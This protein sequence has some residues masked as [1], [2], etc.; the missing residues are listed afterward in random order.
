MN[1]FH[2]EISMENPRLDIRHLQ[3]IRAIGKTGRVVDAA[4]ELGLTPSALS[5]RIREAER[6]LG[7][8]LFERMHKRLRMT[9][10]AEYLARFSDKF[11][12]EM[13]VIEDEVRRMNA[14]IDHVVRIAVENYS[15]YH[16]FPAFLQMFRAKHPAIDIQIMAGYRRDMVTSLLDRQIDLAI[17]AGES[18][19]AATR[20]LHLF[21]DPLVFV[22]AP[23]HPL[24]G[25]ASVSARD[26][27][28]Q[29]FITFTKIP[30]PDQEF[31]RLFRA[32][33][34]YPNWT[35][36]VELPE[37]IV[38]LVAANQGTSILAQWAV[39]PHVASKRILAIPLGPDPVL[40]NWSCKFRTDE[41]ED[42]PVLRV[43]HA[44]QDWEIAGRASRPATV[45]S[46]RIS[47]S[48]M[49]QSPRTSASVP[50]RSSSK[51]NRTKRH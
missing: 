28:G 22:C 13:Y 10:A 45:S 43:A 18:S 50:S 9:A 25:A 16:W 31:A 17:V 39:S 48:P 33:R 19:H 15:A 49:P 4:D 37:A 46:T 44:L 35:A 3:M 36:A 5:H 12:S 47:A 41:P 34:R 24:A 20:S 51:K 38:E 40:M 27:E 8:P 6:R 32:E 14:G 11:L 29:R 30:E 23:E 2:A 21:Q 26:I 42:G 1:N 7:V